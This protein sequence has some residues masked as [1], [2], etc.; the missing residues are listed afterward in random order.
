MRWTRSSPGLPTRDYYTHVNAIRED[1]LKEVSHAA[2]ALVDDS[3]S[4]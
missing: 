2:Q 3:F 4:D 1:R